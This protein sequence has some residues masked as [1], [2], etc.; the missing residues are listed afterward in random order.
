LVDSGTDFR[1]TQWSES[2][3]VIENLDATLVDLRKYGFTIITS[4][5]AATSIIYQSTS[6]GGTITPG[7]KFAVILANLGLVAALYAVDCFYQTIQRAAAHKAIVLEEELK[8]K[9]GLTAMI[10][11]EYNIVKDWLFIEVV[12]SGFVVVSAGLGYAALEGD[13][14]LKW[15]VPVAGALVVLFILLLNYW[16]SLADRKMQNK[17]EALS[18]SNVK[19]AG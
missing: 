17:V 1:V 10:G 18:S 12:Y 8:D 2:R 5:L 3:K 11:I 9:L 19:T 16:T 6:V 13:T 15:L 7:V 4:L 14:L